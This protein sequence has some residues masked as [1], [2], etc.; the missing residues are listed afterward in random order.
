MHICLILLLFFQVDRLPS[1]EPERQIYTYI[2]HVQN[3]EFVSESLWSLSQI[4]LEN[5]EYRQK[6]LKIG[7]TQG[8]EWIDLFDLHPSDPFRFKPDALHD[9]AL[10]FGD[11]HLLLYLMLQTESDVDRRT[12]F[13]EFYSASPKDHLKDLN[14]RIAENSTVHSGDL[15]QDRWDFSTFLILFYPDN[16][17]IDGAQ[18]YEEVAQVLREMIRR[19]DASNLFQ[20][21]FLYAALLETLDRDGKNR[22]ILPYYRQLI[23][24]HSLP[25]VYLKRNLYWNLDVALY[26][27]GYIDRSLEVQ[28]KQTIPLSRLTGDISSLNTI[29]TN[30]GGYLYTIGRYGEAKKIYSSLL[31][32]T[33]DL[34][35]TIHSRLLNNLS[36]VHYKLGETDRYL[37]TQIKALELAVES[38]DH[39]DQLNIYRNLHIYHRNNRNRNLAASY[40]EEALNIAE[41]IQNKNEWASVLISKADYYN[42]FLNDAEGAFSLLSE[43]QLLLEDSGSD[44]LRAR[45]LSQKASLYKERGE[46]N[47]SRELFTEVISINSK[48][49][50]NRDILQALVHLAELELMSGDPS[51]SRKTIEEFNS[52]DLSVADF[53]VLVNARRI[54]AEIAWTEGRIR[55]AETLIDGI[56]QQV[57]ER[58][59]NTAD[60][61]AGYWHVEE[62]YLHLFRLYAELLEGQN[63]LGEMVNVLDQ[64][65]TINDA[66]L[67][68]NPLI[69]SESLSEEELT[70][71]LRIT[72]KL[73]NLRKRI[74]VAGENEKL[75]LQNEISALTARRNQL[76]QQKRS[77]N[78]FRTPPLSDIQSRLEDGEGILH[79]TR[80]LDNLYIALIDRQSITT[81]KLSFTES[82]EELFEKA[83]D[84]LATG[85]T[86]L[87]V[88]H[89]IYSWLELDN[90]PN[91][92]TSLIVVPDSYLYQLPVGVLPV[93]SPS[94]PFSYGSTEYLIEQK[95]VH[96]LNSLNDLF[97]NESEQTYTFD[98]T[99][100]GLSDFEH[101]DDEELLSLPSASHE[102]QHLAKEMNS[103]GKSRAFLNSEATPLAFSSGVSDS[104]ILHVA[105]HSKISEDNPLFSTIYLHPGMDVQ[106]GDS[107]S[108]QI[109][110]Y[111]LYDMDFENELIMLNSCESASGEYFQGA[112][113][114]GFSRTLR[115]AG[116][117]SLVLNLWRVEDQLASEFAIDFYEGLSDGK[118]KPAAL[119]EAKI[120][121]LKNRNANPHYWGAYMLNGN[122]EAVVDTFFPAP[123]LIFIT[124]LMAGLIFLGLWLLRN[125]YIGKASLLPVWSRTVR[126]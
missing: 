10:H 97:R 90:L 84:G 44:R 13:K 109:F 62:A 99:G 113:I 126:I 91:H 110:A 103:V 88:L 19:N 121:F 47:Q 105:S 122:P 39:S 6:F 24:L 117:Q 34:S 94:S 3:G 96:Y 83:L 45:I 52:Y 59:R 68:E 81:R 35:L 31:A 25:D 70:E 53:E 12:Y 116:A 107:L 41:A 30:Q 7:R 18:F 79:I 1:G 119:R 67:V 108:G 58:G 118:T 17:M 75:A 2:Q 42:R 33:T 15:L 69:T 120:D 72:Q 63:R 27:A 9:L 50:N 11:E 82:Q 92:W 87:E 115:Y 86:N 77:S 102:V 73:D 54:E 114:M 111:E 78:L 48:N 51:A 46:Y 106:S 65:K 23:D 49:D 37:E 104:R 100:I 112:G 124:I 56:Y 60:R 36:L 123:L 80:I 16:L 76:M 28:R 14:R 20:R 8:A 101:T 40:I 22:S 55:D 43:A 74:M 98:F 26:K 93:T 57:M 71:N 5:S 21:D 29:L 125:H 61:E 95:E 64:L 32:D 38:G 89:K 66:A 4:Y 85:E